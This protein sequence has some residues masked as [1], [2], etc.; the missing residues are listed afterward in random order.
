MGMNA[1]IGAKKNVIIIPCRD[2]TMETY[3]ILTANRSKHVTLYTHSD[4]IVNMCMASFADSQISINFVTEIDTLANEKKVS[5]LCE[6]M[7]GVVE[8]VPCSDP[9]SNTVRITPAVV[10]GD[11]SRRV[12]IIK[13]TITSRMALMRWYNNMIRHMDVGG[14]CIDCQI[15]YRI[16]RPIAFAL[17][18]KQI[19]LDEDGITDAIPN[20]FVRVKTTGMVNLDD[21]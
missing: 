21:T 18:D 4:T 10:H 6:R 5:D 7:N 12:A 8:A 1:Y 17:S 15:M 2:A 16:A 11:M 20:F 9:S 14:A 19:R 13:R 3:R